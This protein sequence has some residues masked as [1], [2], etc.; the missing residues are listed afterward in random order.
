MSSTSSPTR[1]FP[2]EAV[3][4]ILCL[5]LHGVRALNHSHEPVGD[6]IRYLSC[7]RNITQGFLVPDD[8]PDFVN[9]P[10]Y[11]ALLAPFLAFDLSLKWA[12]LLNAFL[13]SG[14][15]MLL[16][17]TVKHYEGLGWAVASAVFLMVHPNT[18]R[19]TPQ[20]LT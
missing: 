3:I 18:L 15:V 7:A 17:R 20:L 1:Q 8:N 12:R 19:I 5:S 6:E 11:P 2:W 13:I 9:G 14:A 10:G 16:F 4:L